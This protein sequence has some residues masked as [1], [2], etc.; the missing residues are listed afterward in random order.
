MWQAINH[1]KTKRE[2]R[3]ALY[4]VCCRI[5]ELEAQID[6]RFKRLEDEE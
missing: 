3:N 2:L 4:F 5:Q 1:A 6:N